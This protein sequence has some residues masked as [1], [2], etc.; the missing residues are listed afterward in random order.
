M[1]ASGDPRV[2]L[3]L[4]LYRQGVMDVEQIRR[5]GTALGLAHGEL[6]QLLDRCVGLLFGEDDLAE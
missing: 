6:R 3:L 4:G 5:W 1:N 2:V